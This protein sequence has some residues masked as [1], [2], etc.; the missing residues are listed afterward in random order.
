M[1]SDHR[2]PNRPVVACS[3]HNDHAAPGGVCER[4]NELSESRSRAI[5][6]GKTQVDDAH[7]RVDT[8]L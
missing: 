1:L 7:T 8:F 6:E 3:R 4:G 2:A 5:A